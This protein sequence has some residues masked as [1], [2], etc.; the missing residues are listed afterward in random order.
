VI[1]WSIHAVHDLT[2]IDPGGQLQRSGLGAKEFGDGE[3]TLPTPA[4]HLLT[5]AR[6]TAAGVAAAE[7]T[8]VRSSGEAVCL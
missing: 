7:S 3:S 6:V 8:S 2:G 4:A 5:T 1:P